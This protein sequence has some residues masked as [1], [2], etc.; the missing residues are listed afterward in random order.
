MDIESGTQSFVIKVWLEDT[1]EEAARATWRGHITHVP[2][3]E[4][5]YFKSPEEVTAFIA[6]RLEAMG[7]TPQPRDWAERWIERFRARLRRTRK[8]PAN[9]DVRHHH[10][11]PEKTQCQQDTSKIRRS[12]RN[13]ANTS[14]QKAS[15]Q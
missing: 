8:V 11:E 3:G 14:E 1:G 6:S 4:K 2:S 10:N 9:K 15:S 13:E 12:V 7:A 5:R